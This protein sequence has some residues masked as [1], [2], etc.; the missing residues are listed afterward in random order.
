MNDLQLIMGAILYIA[1]CG[2]M[3]G[4]QIEKAPMHYLPVS[5]FLSILVFRIIIAIS[6]P[7]TAPIM[8]IKSWDELSEEDNG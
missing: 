2:S 3:L 4:Y 6:W 8:F 1:G 7:I 5:D